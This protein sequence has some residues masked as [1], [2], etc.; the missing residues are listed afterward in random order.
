MADKFSLVLLHVML[1]KLL[2][3]S[4]G[5]RSMSI[6][7]RG[8]TF[9]LRKRVPKRFEAVESRSTVWISLHTDS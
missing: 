2:H 3:K 8:D 1:H 7:K 4:I 6:T 9:Y 5:R